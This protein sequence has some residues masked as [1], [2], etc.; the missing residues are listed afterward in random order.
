[1]NPAAEVITEAS[2][3][4]PT[5]SLEAEQSVLGA[6]LL[7]NAA[8]ATARELIS[9]ADFYRTGHQTI[10]RAMLELAERGDAIDN[11]TLTEHLG[12]NGLL[13]RIGGPAYLAELVSVTPS[14]ANIRQHCRIVTEKTRLRQLQRLLLTATE[15]INNGANL[16]RLAS[17]VAPIQTLTSPEEDSANAAEVTEEDS[18]PAFPEDAW[19]GPFL[20][21][22]AA[23]DGTSEAP[24]TAHFAAFWATV[25][26]RLRRRVSFYMA[27]PHF[28]NVFLVSYGTTGDS[29]TSAAR[30]ALRLLPPDGQVKVLRGIGSAEALGDW[31]AQPEGAPPV[32]HLLFVEEISTL[33]TR[34]G[35]EGS[36]VLSFLTETYDC[37]DVYEVPFR[38][39]PVRV[40]EP[41]PTLLAGTTPEWFWKSMREIDIHGGFGNRLFFLTG[42]PKPP[43]PLPT[44]PHG[45]YLHRVQQALAQ[46]DRIERCELVLEQQA[47]TLWAE[48]YHAWKI[49]PWAPLTAAAVKRIP[50]YIIKLAMTY[51]A[52]EQT[53]P[54]IRA[55]QLAA[56]MKVGHYGA[57]C[58]QRLME[59][60]QLQTRQGQLESR[61]CQVLAGGPLPV[62]RIHQ[63]ISGRFS[64]EDVNRAIKSLEV[65]EIIRVVKRTSRG[66]PVYGLRHGAKRDE[67]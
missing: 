10:Y 14:A 45:E 19:R 61:V 52:L 54:V 23:M 32:S 36:T 17:L 40:E 26:A 33:L 41:T 30:Q 8:L 21:Y 13:D 59:R 24:D 35:W 39:N 57:R 46:L 67:T 22:R 60:H 48:F 49:T 3:H 11:L 58:A 56:A 66:G 28:A 37:P 12:S 63:A 15:A 1:M 38:K 16:E 31:M 47:K 2:P 7:E 44:K 6:I 4:I 51:A 53:V 55:D 42:R 34:G 5:H 25:A 50:A 9:D 62:W 43:I 65:P 27:F 18:L 64:A 20:D 29:K